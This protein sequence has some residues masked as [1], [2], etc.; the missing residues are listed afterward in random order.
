MIW[1]F[2]VRNWL[3]IGKVDM[4]VVFVEYI[5]ILF[6]NSVL[7]LVYL[8]SRWI[9]LFIVCVIFGLLLSVVID[10]I[11]G[12]LFVVV[13]SCDLKFLY[14]VLLMGLCSWMCGVVSNG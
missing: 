12:F 10:V 1:L 5:V 14:I 13:I 4:K 6:R 8:C 11:S 3:L 7:C 9:W 2:W